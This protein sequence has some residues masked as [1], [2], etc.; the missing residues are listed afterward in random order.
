M[1]EALEE[2][3]AH[4]HDAIAQAEVTATAETAAAVAE[5]AAEELRQ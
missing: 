3:M 5:A 4:V 2:D 1:E